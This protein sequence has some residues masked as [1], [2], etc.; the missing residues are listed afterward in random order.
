[1]RERK[2]TALGQ[3]YLVRRGGN[4]ENNLEGQHLTSR[5]FTV[6]HGFLL[7]LRRSPVASNSSGKPFLVPY[8]L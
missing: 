3:E 2:D 6:Q 8:E 4:G 7:F 5:S 1:M